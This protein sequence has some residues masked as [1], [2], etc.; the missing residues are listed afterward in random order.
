MQIQ[1]HLD[2]V[3]SFGAVFA[4]ALSPCCFPLL[5]VIAASL[6]LGA[7]EQ[8][9][10]Q[11]QYAVQFFVLLAVAGS[12]MA[13]RVHRHL[14]PLILSIT[15]AALCFIH[16]YFWYS[17]TLIY[18]GFGLLV[19]SG[20]WNMRERSRLNSGKTTFLE[21]TITC[22]ECGH[23]QTEVMPKDACQFFWDCPRCRVKVKPNQGDC[24]V[25]CSFGS[26]PCPP[27]QME[28]G[29]CG[30]EQRTENGGAFHGGSRAER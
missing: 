4:A 8:F 16:Y 20:L 25:F 26:I 21:S 11:L 14:P 5:G 27:L 10:P 9:A 6:G 23:Q 13:Y 29:R 1:N 22:P 12:S 19:I 2:K 3:G 24:C 15:G 18:S 30:K 7:A 17:E 28:R